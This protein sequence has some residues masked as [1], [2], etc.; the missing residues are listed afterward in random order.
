MDEIQLYYY[1]KVFETS[2]LRKK[3]NAFQDFF[4]DIMERCY[5]GD[6]FRTRPWGPIGDRKNDGYL[7]SQRTLYQVYAPNDMDSK[8]ALKKIDEDFHGAL[9]YWEKYFDTW[10]FVHNARDGLGP[11]VVEK[12]LSLAEAHAP[13]CVSHCGFPELLIHFRKL[14]FE[15][16]AALLGAFPSRREMQQVRLDDVQVVLR[17]IEQSEEASSQE[18]HAVSPNKLVANALSSAVR[19]YLQLGMLKVHLVEKLF[20]EYYDP[21]YGDSLAE[22]FRNQY[23]KLRSQ[24]I[25]PDDIFWHLQSFTLGDERGTP[26]QEAAALTVLA[27][28]FQA[29]D[30]F[31]APRSEITG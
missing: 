25:L 29:C 27:Y 3:G 14:P 6:F 2:F 5:P 23:I 8:E 31:E 17:T 16:A 11:E 9:P 19:Q 4:A 24:S 13:L 18:V 21:R 20:K 26:R 15:D 28:F 7:K 1:E 12:L 10:I 22:T 30:I